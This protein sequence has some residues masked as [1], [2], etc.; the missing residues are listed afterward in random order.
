M[1]LGVVLCL[2]ILKYVPGTADWQLARLAGIV[3]FGYAAFLALRLIQ[4]EEAVQ[5]DGWSELRASPVEVFGALGGAGA[6]GAPDDGGGLQRRAGRSDT[7]AGRRRLRA[8]GC[9]RRSVGGAILYTSVMVR[10]R[11]NQAAVERR[12][13]QGSVTAIAWADVVKVQGRWTGITITAAD[14]RTMSFSPLQSGA[15]QLAKF[16]QRRAQLNARAPSPAILGQG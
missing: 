4:G 5:V 16:A 6:C 14:K 13:A 7:G 2:V 9:A 10:V 12:D 15:A 8:R 3:S 1:P 11:W